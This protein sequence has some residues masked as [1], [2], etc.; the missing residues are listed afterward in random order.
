MVYIRVNLGKTM[1]GTGNRRASLGQGQGSSTC[2]FVMSSADLS[3]PSDRGLYALSSRGLFSAEKRLRP[4]A[5]RTYLGAP[6]HW[7][8]RQDRFFT[9]FWSSPV[10]CRC[11]DSER[12][13]RS[14]GQI[15]W[16]IEVSKHGRESVTVTFTVIVTTIYPDERPARSRPLYLSQPS[17]VVS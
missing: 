17:T 4:S 12:R 14:D 1:E 7:V 13:V 2:Q 15:A 11:S 9:F 3:H 10:G 6:F 8:V 5:R 16:M